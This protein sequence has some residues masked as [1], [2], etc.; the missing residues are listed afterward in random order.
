[1][2]LIRAF[3]CVVIPPV[4]VLD[5]GLGAIALTTLLWCWSW[6]LGI[7]A[8]LIFATRVK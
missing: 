6:L 2:G 1:M 5:K 4:A 8:A 7:L 3:F